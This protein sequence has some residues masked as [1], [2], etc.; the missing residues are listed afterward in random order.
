MGGVRP[1]PA[2]GARRPGLPE[3]DRGPAGL[4]KLKDATGGRLRIFVSGGAPLS[5][6]IAK[7]FYAAGLPILEGIRID[8]DVTGH[9]GQHL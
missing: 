6:D 8:R 2:S 5:A 4:L 9:R 3:A 7:F 1:G